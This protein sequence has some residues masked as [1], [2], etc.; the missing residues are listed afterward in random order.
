MARN[1]IIVRVK[2]FVRV[3]MLPDTR[4]SEKIKTI[5]VRQSQKYLLALWAS[6]FDYHLS[7]LRFYLPETHF[8]N[9]TIKMTE[10]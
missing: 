1:S 2:G 9:E 8:I 7:K 5:S 10:K 6:G 3:R 4:I